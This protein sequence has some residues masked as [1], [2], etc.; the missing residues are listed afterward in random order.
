M[1]GINAE[2]AGRRAGRNSRRR[3]MESFHWA[4]SELFPVLGVE[5]VGDVDAKQGTGT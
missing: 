1:S 3:T 4:F 5:V 2:G